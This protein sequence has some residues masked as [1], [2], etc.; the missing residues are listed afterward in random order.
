MQPSHQYY[1]VASAGLGLAKCKCQIYNV[2]HSGAD[3]FM[4]IQFFIILANTFLSY[5]V[6][7][8]I[9]Q[10]ELLNIKLRLL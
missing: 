5:Y 4:I 10:R 1:C 7:L 8:A 9:N 2:V 3:Y 6:V